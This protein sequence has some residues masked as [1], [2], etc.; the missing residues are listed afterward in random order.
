MKITEI[1]SSK[2]NPV[3]GGKSEESHVFHCYQCIPFEFFNLHVLSILY[4]NQIFLNKTEIFK[5]GNRN[6]IGY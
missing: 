1:A 5:I 2:E 3:A 4:S 6:N